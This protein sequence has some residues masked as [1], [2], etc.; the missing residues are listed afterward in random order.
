MR[1]ANYD[2][3][4]KMVEKVIFH[5]NYEYQVTVVER[6]SSFKVTEAI[7]SAYSKS[8]FYFIWIRKLKTF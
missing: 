1:I 6:D 4:K 2:N 7:R 8:M 3:I 5:V